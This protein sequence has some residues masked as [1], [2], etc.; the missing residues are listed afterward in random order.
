M[1]RFL[2]QLFVLAVVA[3]PRL[4]HATAKKGASSPALQAKEDES[5]DDDDEGEDDERIVSVSVSASDELYVGRGLLLNALKLGL[6]GVPSGAFLG[7]SYIAAHADGTTEHFLE[8]AGSDELSERWS[9]GGELRGFPV[10]ALLPAVAD[11]S[12]A[13]AG[14]L[15]FLGAHAY[16]AR[17][18]D[19]A[20]HSA[21]EVGAGVAANRFGLDE[22]VR[23]ASTRT[24]AVLSFDAFASL[25]SASGTIAAEGSFTPLDVGAR[26]FQSTTLDAALHEVAAMTLPPRW[27]V[28]VGAER[29]FGDWALAADL[30]RAVLMDDVARWEASGELQW[31][32]AAGLWVLAGAVV[33]ADRGPL[34][35]AWEPSAY[36]MLGVRWSS[37]DAPGSSRVGSFR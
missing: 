2:L 1:R 10:A 32:V 35:T 21:L 28:A 13:L 29:R 9:V 20:R 36:A 11:G 26:V 33:Q 5:D 14:S 17:N 31:R 27:H 22:N 37:A 19:I 15:A 8:L 24:E 3:T 4:A 7:L 30:R 18:W 34:T 16:A 23:S 25:E 6:D 12:A